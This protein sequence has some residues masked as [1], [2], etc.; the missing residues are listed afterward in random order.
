M[1]H[2]NK[3]LKTIVDPQPLSYEAPQFPS[4][5]WPFPVSG[6]QTVYLYDAWTI[7]RFTLLWT[8]IDV[9]GVHLVAA[10]YAMVIQ[11]RNWR[12]IWITPIVFGIIGGIEALIAGSVVGGV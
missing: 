5:Y 10:A 3:F 7:F 1:S 4:L 2:S 12:L 8:L 11:W 9:I 6:T